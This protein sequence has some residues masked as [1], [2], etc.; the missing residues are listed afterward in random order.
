MFRTELDVEPGYLET[1]FFMEV[2]LM[3]SDLKN[4]TASAGEI[5]KEGVREEVEFSCAQVLT[6]KVSRAV[7]GLSHYVPFQFDRHFYSVVNAS[8]HST[9]IDY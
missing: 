7:M 2:E 3:F 9:L 4:L 8:L 6:Y 1:E 5:L